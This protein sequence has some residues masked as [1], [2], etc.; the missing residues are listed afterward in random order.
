MTTSLRLDTD[1]ERLLRRLE[2]ERGQSR[3]AIVRA[4]IHALA[5]S[6]LAQD[7]T[8]GHYEA[9]KPFIGRVQSGGLNLSKRTG[10]Q[11]ARLLVER[12]RARRPR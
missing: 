7:K 9:L 6:E 1:T 11:F 10:E 2:R 12:Q 5:E 3:S 4:A 8:L